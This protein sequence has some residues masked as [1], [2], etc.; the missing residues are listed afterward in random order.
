MLVFVAML[1][2]GA[3]A[4]GSVK[5]FVCYEYSVVAAVDTSKDPWRSC[6]SGKKPPCLHVTLPSHR[7]SSI[8]WLYS[9]V[10]RAVAR[11]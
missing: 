5:Q 11:Q 7:E 3:T 10:R 9:R 4:E 2:A 8:G 1:E 6:F